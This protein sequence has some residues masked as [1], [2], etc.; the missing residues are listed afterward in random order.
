[1]KVIITKTLFSF[2]ILTTVFAGGTENSIALRLE[3]SLILE[4][5]PVEKYSKNQFFEIASAL[6][7]A[8]ERVRIVTFN[9]LINKRD[10]KTEECYRW[11]QR[12][13]RIV[14]VLEELAPDVIG[15]QELYQSQLDDLLAQIGSDY[16]FY[17][18][19]RTDGE[20]NGVFYR[21]SRFELVGSEVWTI[22]GVGNNV[23]MVQLQDLKTGQLFAVFNSHISF[24]GPD[25]REEEIQFILKQ[26][27]SV[28]E[29][30]PVL[31]SAD[32]NIFPNRLDLDTLPFYDGDYIHRLLTKNVFK[33]SSEVSLLGH[34]GPL[35]TYTN[36]PEDKK[37]FP[38]PFKGTGTP[39]VILDHIYVSKEITVLTHAVQPATVNGHYPSDHLPLVIDCLINE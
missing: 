9:M 2:L 33:D 24:D 36:T 1:M 20:V 6:Q 14:E 16:S 34:L 32:F 19:P 26:I 39:G 15:A 5:L 12:L 8:Q 31:F 17:G 21:K 28:A 4:N 13:P 3:N 37:V 7:H 25:D 10:Y 27:H 18:K 11:P 38:T 35:S 29:K 23:T 30:M 22:P